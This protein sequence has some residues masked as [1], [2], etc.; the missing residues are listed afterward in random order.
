M[1]MLFKI[2]N[3]IKINTEAYRCH[4]HCKVEKIFY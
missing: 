2:K 1:S 3:H 4:T